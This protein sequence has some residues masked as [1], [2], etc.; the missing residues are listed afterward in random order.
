MKVEMKEFASFE[1]LVIEANMPRYARDGRVFPALNFSRSPLPYGTAER[2]RPG[3][4][5]HALWHADASKR[6]IE[7]RIPWGL[8]LIADPSSHQAFAGTDENWVPRSEPTP[9]I[10]VAVF[11]LQVSGAGE[12]A[13]KILRSS[14][15]PLDGPRLATEPA[16][17]SWKGWTRVEYRPYF[18]PSYFALQRIFADFA[19][20]APISD[21]R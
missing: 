15:P 21:A 9:G 7:V 11:A 14:L 13:E 6:M 4:S 2:G 16:L 20:K 1:E 17:Y 19:R 8:L 3:H 10:S 18:K 12:R 5:S